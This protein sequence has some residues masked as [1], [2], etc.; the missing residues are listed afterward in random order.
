MTSAVYF[1]DNKGKPILSRRF[2]DD[3]PLNA[4]DKFQV[5]LSDLEEESSIIPPCITHNGIQYLFIQHNDLYIVALAT[6]LATNIAEIFTFLHKMMDILGDYLKTVEEESI[7]DNFVI[8]YELL[9]EMMD[10]GIPQITETKMLKKYITQKS[11]KLVRAAKKKRNAARPPSELTNSVSWR[12]EGIKYKKNEAFLD[13]IESINMLMTQ[14]GKVLRSEILGSVKVKSRLSGMPDLKLGINDRGIFTKYLDGNN[15]GV[16][17]E[18]SD[19]PSKS[20]ESSITNT[21]GK[22]KTNIELEDLK[23]HQCVRL[24]KFENEKIITF[25]PPDGD[26]EL[27]SYRLNTVIKPLIWCNMK[28]K[29]HS[30]SRI[31]I[32][33][34]AKAQIKKK[35]VATNV[36][37]IIPVPEDADTPTFKYSHGKIKWVPEQ[38]AIVWKIHTFPGGK[39]YAMSA[40]LGL[41]SINSEEEPK[42]KRPVQ[43]KFQIPYFTTSGIQV[44]YLKINEPKLQYKSYPW[45]RYITQN[46]DDYTIRLS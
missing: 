22:T 11:F 4:I 5:V 33:C 34:T 2:K 17:L 25:I 14:N 23:F 41:P 27:M 26:F 42:F 1:C 37:I 30:K 8:V 13:I 12:A 9:D 32:F 10:F 38:N 43:V 35:S 46:G 29:V 28:V 7:R 39:E 18:E 21:N 3:V 20:S 19:Q 16:T 31:E 15:I 44:R 24:S 40:E 6:S 36:E 45:V